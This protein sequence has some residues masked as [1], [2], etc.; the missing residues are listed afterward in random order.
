MDGLDCANCHSSTIYPYRDKVSNKI[1]C[2]RC[3]KLAIHLGIRFDFDFE[4]LF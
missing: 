4:K 2:E 1:V 3:M